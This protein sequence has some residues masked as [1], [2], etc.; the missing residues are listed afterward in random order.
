MTS[1][2]YTFSEKVQWAKKQN[3]KKA[4]SQ[5][6]NMNVSIPNVLSCS[7]N[8]N[9]YMVNVDHAPVAC[10]HMGVSSFF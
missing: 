5:E 1:C 6:M 8:T 2:M 7:I 10:M 3:F 4:S 9:N